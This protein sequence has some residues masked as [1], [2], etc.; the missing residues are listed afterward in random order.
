MERA[1]KISVLGTQADEVARE[2][3][4]GFLSDHGRVNALL[5]EHTQGSGTE[6]VHARINELSESL[7][8][9]AKA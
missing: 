2:K 1:A 6:Q 4:V 3:V 8:A 5:A 7:L 9:L